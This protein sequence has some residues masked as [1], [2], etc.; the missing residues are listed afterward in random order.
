MTF[1]LTRTRLNNRNSTASFALMNL[2]IVEAGPSDLDAAL[3]VERLAFGQEDEAELVGALLRDPTA[4]PCLSLLALADNEPLGHI[5]FT[6]VTIEGAATPGSAAILAP[7]AVRPEV[8]RRGIGQGLI[9][10]GVRRLA[11]SG[12]RL[13]FVLGD[14]SYYTKSGF[15][16]A[17][18]F[19]LIPPYPV[20]P[21]EAWM[22]RPL[23]PNALNTIS[24]RVSCAQSLDKPEYWRE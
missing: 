4:R 20:D 15:V 12:I 23:V 14:P 1:G 6:A 7:L 21:Q 3:R 8:Q 5:L 24:G 2:N 13:L 10:E 16:P 9:E 11:A 17:M 18:P 22:V 19:G